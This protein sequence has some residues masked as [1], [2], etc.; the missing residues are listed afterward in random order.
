MEPFDQRDLFF[1]ARAKA[2]VVAFAQVARFS[3]VD[4]G[5]SSAQLT[6]TPLGH[7]PRLGKT[8]T[9][10]GNGGAGS[11]ISPRSLR[12]A[13]PSENKTRLSCWEG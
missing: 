13:A 10:T 7:S 6:I 3:L 4:N 11:S 5:I 2:N 12:A 9:Y 1:G 8:N